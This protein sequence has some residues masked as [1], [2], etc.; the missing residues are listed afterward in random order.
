[1]SVPAKLVK[2]IKLP[3]IGKV[4]KTYGIYN[5]TELIY[6]FSSFTEAGGV[7]KIDMTNPEYPVQ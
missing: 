6:T 7:Y 1:M 3:D 5:E 2:N 4:S